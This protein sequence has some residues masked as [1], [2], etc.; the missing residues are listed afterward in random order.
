MAVNK[1]AI[2]PGRTMG[3][4]IVLNSEKFG[5]FRLGELSPLNPWH[6]PPMHFNE[7]VNFSDFKASPASTY[8]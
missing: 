6:A 1:T 3:H 5:G 4:N 8:N 7:E 2:V